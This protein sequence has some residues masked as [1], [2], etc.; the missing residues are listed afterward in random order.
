MLWRDVPL[1]AGANDFTGSGHRPALH[2]LL[3]I[4]NLYILAFIHIQYLFQI[5]LLLH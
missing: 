4:T 3:N 5:A 2:R 1:F